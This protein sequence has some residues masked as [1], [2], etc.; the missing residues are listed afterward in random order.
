M[1]ALPCYPPTNAAIG[2]SYGRA[3]SCAVAAPPKAG[4]ASA[5]YRK[6][7]SIHGEDVRVTIKE[8]QMLFIADRDSEKLLTAVRDEERIEREQLTEYFA[9][10]AQRA[11]ALRLKGNLHRT[12]PKREEETPVVYE[13]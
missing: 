9:A 3:A 13:R 7:S 1:S 11:K 8:A 5:N 12:L 4:A 10:L 6:N 2:I